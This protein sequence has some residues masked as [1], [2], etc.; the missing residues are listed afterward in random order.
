MNLKDLKNNLLLLGT[1][2]LLS[3][4]FIIVPSSS[5]AQIPA[6]ATT[7]SS[8][9]NSDEKIQKEDV[10]DLIDTLENEQSRQEFLKNLK[11]LVKVKEKKEEKQ[12]G[13]AGIF[14][15]NPKTQKW[16]KEYNSFLEENNINSSTIG[17]AF[18]TFGLLI[19]AVICF[20]LNKKLINFINNNFQK[21]K[22]KYD[23][24]HSRFQIY[25]KIVRYFANIILAMIFIY[26][27]GFLWNVTD[28]GVFE[29]ELG[30]Q[31][32]GSFFNIFI[33]SVVGIAIWEGLSIAIDHV[34]KSSFA[35]QSNRMRTLLPIIQN[36]LFVT[37]AILYTLIILSELGVDIMPLL[38]GA[39]IVGVAIGFGAQTMVKDFLNGFTI[40]LED[41]I[42]VGDVVK[43]ADRRGWVER[44]TIRKVQ[45]RDLD[46]TVYTVP[47]SEIS[48]VENLT[49]D[50]SYYLMDVGVA[51]RENTDEVVKYLREVDEDLRSDDAFKN[52]IL[53]P[54]E[55]LGVDAFADSAVIIKARI[56]TRPVKQWRVG[57][58]YNRRMKHKFDENNVEIPFPHQTLYFGEDKEGKAP[59]AP[60]RLENMQD[61][62][63]V[64]NKDS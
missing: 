44:I 41:L 28:F 20:F 46:G 14:N 30:L 32:L 37:F 11:A 6:A 52:D 34:M 55:I 64:E 22:I 39:G 51:Y 60:I 48:V 35:E 53:E 49:K 36:V 38:A 31:F 40:I 13:F 58:E 2:F 59:P 17:K 56:K 8:E 16:V 25:T 43:I 27:I 42:Q 12:D 45:L 23:I 57:R 19:I 10:T 50:F 7:T 9:Q 33:I 15:F 61:V 47:F 63:T 3:I 24:H 26:A 21:L 1:L 18:L 4:S 54:I 62:K 5:F 29:S